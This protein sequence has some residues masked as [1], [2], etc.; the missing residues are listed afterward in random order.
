VVESGGI[1]LST[2]SYCR[3]CHTYIKIAG[4][5][6]KSAARAIYFQGGHAAHHHHLIIDI[7]S[8]YTKKKKAHTRLLCAAA[9]HKVHCPRNRVSKSARFLKI[10]GQQMSMFQNF[11]EPRSGPHQHVQGQDRLAVGAVDDP[12]HF[13][14]AIPSAGFRWLATVGL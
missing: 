3:S 4:N 5:V 8:T 11:L 1:L 12:P 14:G 7:V 10:N 13:P 9:C 2:S 6:K